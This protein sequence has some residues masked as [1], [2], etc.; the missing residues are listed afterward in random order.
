MRVLIRQKIDVDR[1]GDDATVTRVLRVDDRYY[2][3]VRHPVGTRYNTLMNA[4]NS[5]IDKF[6][7]EQRGRL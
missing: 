4:I 7:Y 3:E 1:D 6:L 5:A 2:V